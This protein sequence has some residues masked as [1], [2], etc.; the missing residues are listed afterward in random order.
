MQKMCPALSCIKSELGRRRSRERAGQDVV[1]GNGT[2]G[3]AATIGKEVLGVG[4]SDYNHPKTADSSHCQPRRRC[5]CC[6]QS[7]HRSYFCEAH[8]VLA[9]SSARDPGAAFNGSG[10]RY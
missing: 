9:A 6:Y 1:Q 3:I 10:I 2:V 8:A 5:R 4:F 7:N